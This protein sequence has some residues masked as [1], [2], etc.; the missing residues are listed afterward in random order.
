[1]RI[2][3]GALKRSRVLV[4]QRGQDPDTGHRI[5]ARYISEDILRS[6]D[7]VPKK[8]KPGHKTGRMD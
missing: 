5:A 6:N 3:V 7:V 4:K 1:M 2:I 8:L